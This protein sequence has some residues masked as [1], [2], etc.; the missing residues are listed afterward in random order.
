MAGFDDIGKI[1]NLL[2]AIDKA[3]LR[4]FFNSRNSS[5]Y[6]IRWIFKNV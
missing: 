4:K 1:K 6:L 5:E 2:T 3:K